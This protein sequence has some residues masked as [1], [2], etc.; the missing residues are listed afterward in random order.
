MAAPAF[1]WLDSMMWSIAASGILLGI[2]A[3]RLHY[4]AKTD[5]IEDE[6]KNVSTGLGLTL[7]ITGF[8]LFITGIMISFM[9]PAAFGGRFSILFGGA[10]ALGGLVIVSV[11]TAILLRRGLQASSYFA[12][13][14]GIYLVVDA[15]SIITYGMTKS[16][17]ESAILYAAPAVAM[18][19][20]VPA[21]HLNSRAARWVFAVFAILFAIGWIFLAYNTTMGHLAP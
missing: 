20:S 8:Y 14:V 4:N 15:I 19:L 17:T 5:A 21:T 2:S 1:D 6:N 11:A 13:I 7:G 9:T 16:P 18:F 10:G 3:I 12:F